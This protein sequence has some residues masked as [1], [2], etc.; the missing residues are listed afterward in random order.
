MQDELIKMLLSLLAGALLGIEREY[1]F[2]SAGIRTIAMISVGSTLFTLMSLQIG[3][4]NSP[5]RIASNILTGIGF[6][7]AGVIFKNELSVSGLTTAATIWVS[8]AI[9]MAI[10]NGY[11]ELAFITLAISL[12]V[13][14][15]LRIVQEKLNDYHQIRVYK[16]TYL[17]DKI[18]NLEL[19]GVFK[20]YSIAFKKIKEFRNGKEATCVYELTGHYAQLDNMNEQLMRLQLIDSF[21]Y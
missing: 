20:E 15:V 21:V 6:I 12:G 11:F 2:K 19:E 8:A 1:K 14:L 3:G 16:F 13:L 18:S 9:G 7:G 4:H 5:D 10:G 17:I